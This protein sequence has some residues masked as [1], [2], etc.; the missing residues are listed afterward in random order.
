MH[1]LSV[2]SFYCEQDKVSMAAVKVTDMTKPWRVFNIQNI[3]LE[4]QI[5]VVTAS[6]IW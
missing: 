3:I 4:Q 2:F 5:S 1:I 6:Y